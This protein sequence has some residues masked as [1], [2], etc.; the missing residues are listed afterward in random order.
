MTTRILRSDAP[1]VAQVTRLQQPAGEGE[2]QIT[3][4]GS[5][6]FLTF[7]EWSATAVAAA[8]NASKWPEFQEARATVSRTDVLLTSTLAGRPFY[9]SATVGGHQ[10]AS[11]VQTITPVNHVTGGTATA[12][13]L[14]E[15]TAG[16]NPTTTT[17]ANLKT[18]FEALPGGI[19]AAD[20]LSWTGL[21]GGPWTVTFGGRYAEQPVPLITIDASAVTGGTA[22]TDEKQRLSM[23]P[24]ATD[25]ISFMLR[26]PD[27]LQTTSLLTTPLTAAALQTALAAIGYTTTCTGGPLANGS[28][29]EYEWVTRAGRFNNTAVLESTGFATAALVGLA[30]GD[31]G[32]STGLILMTLAQVQGATIGNGQLLVTFGAGSQAIPGMTIRAVAADN[33]TW[34]AN[35]AAAVANTLTTAFANFDIPAIPSTGPSQTIDIDVRDLLQE[36]VNRPG[37]D[38]GNTILFYLVPPPTAH[39]AAFDAISSGELSPKLIVST[40]SASIDI[41]WT[42]PDANTDIPQLLVVTSG[43]YTYPPNIVTIQDG[44]PAKAPGIVVAMA[45]AGG[46]S[47]VIRDD[48][49]SRG[50]NHYDDPLNWEADDG[51]FQVPEDGDKAYIESGRGDLLYGLNQRSE[52]VALLAVNKI[53]LTDVHHFWEGQAVRLITTN[54]LPGGLAADTTYYVLNIGGP[55]LQ[56]SATPGGAPID[57]TTAGTGVHTLGVKLLSL[58]IQARYSGKLGLPRQSGTNQ[59]MYFEYRERY[60]TVWCDRIKLGTGDG[61]GSSRMN[62][63]TGKLPTTLQAIASA[64]QAETGVN[65][66]LWRGTHTDNAIEALGADLGIALF[67]EESATFD[68]LQQRGGTLTLGQNVTGGSID[69]TGGSRNSLGAVIAGELIL[70]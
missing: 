19:V 32:E 35:H 56:L 25:P 13:W 68:T 62:I 30:P 4:L 22:A 70:N 5:G 23:D 37:W 49:R 3:I 41:E 9:V 27:T 33:A 47:L 11:A 48:V 18:M 1:A 69:A 66:V 65:A 10:F 67:P 12:T 38:S 42:G 55:Y 46:E 31:A 15:T 40:D 34:P 61:S 16:W 63:D 20:E 6:K 53:R 60:L 28:G 54:T 36:L 43:G 24:A 21:A 58:D 2:V 26:R 39:Y 29:W 8:W 64:G 57:I 7:V 45:V 51:T 50:P 52:F 14:G 17:G 59:S 44:S